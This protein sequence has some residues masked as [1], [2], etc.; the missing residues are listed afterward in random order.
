MCIKV[1]EEVGIVK[2]KIL[3]D[4]GYGF[5]KLLEYNYM[6]VKYLLLFMKLGYLVLVGMFCKLMIGN[7]LNRK[8]DECLV[9]SISFVIIV[10]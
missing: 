5:G 1:C 8:V 6:L 7:L 4:F 2:D 9:G 3:F 10:V